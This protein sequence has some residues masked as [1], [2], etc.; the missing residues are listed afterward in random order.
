MEGASGLETPRALDGQN[1]FD[2][3]VRNEPNVG[4][5]SA[6]LDDFDEEQKQS[7]DAADVVIANESFQDT[8]GDFY[9][10]DG[11]E[12]DV[13][14]IFGDFDNDSNVNTMAMALTS[15]GV[16]TEHTQQVALSM[17]QH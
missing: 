11:N 9:E 16:N 3:S 15:S 10:D 7:R 2:H 14:E 5:P 8:Y 1:I 6:A 4:Q 17:C 13:A 12:M